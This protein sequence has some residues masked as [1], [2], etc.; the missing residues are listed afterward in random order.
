MNSFGLPSQV[1]QFLARPRLSLFLVG[2]D[3]SVPPDAHTKAA[4][5]ILKTLFSTRPFHAV[6]VCAATKGGEDD[7]LLTL[8]NAYAV[9]E[10]ILGKPFRSLRPVELL[11]R[12]IRGK[13]EVRNLFRGTRVEQFWKACDATACALCVKWAEDVLC[14][15]ALAAESDPLW[16][17][18]E[19]PFPILVTLPPLEMILLE[20]H[21]CNVNI[22]PEHCRERFSRQSIAPFAVSIFRWNEEGKPH[23]QALPMWRV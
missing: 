21:L 11:Q 23:F 16:W 12:R 7:M 1:K 9:R 14:D 10:Q 6:F 2:I 18:E 17:R 22:I 8:S 5:P 19:V 4:Q 20:A 3:P 13:G 15:V